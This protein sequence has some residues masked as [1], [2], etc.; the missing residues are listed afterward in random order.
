MQESK[1]QLFQ[2]WI[3]CGGSVVFSLRVKFSLSSKM[4]KQAGSFL[5][6]SFSLKTRL[7]PQSFGVLSCGMRRKTA[8][9]WM[10]LF[11]WVH[12]PANPIPWSL[13]NSQKCKRI[14][15]K[16]SKCKFKF[17]FCAFMDINCCKYLVLRKCVFYVFLW[18]VSVNTIKRSQL[19]TLIATEKCCSNNYLRVIPKTFHIIFY[20][21]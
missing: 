4:V 12:G 14:A 16:V 7:S 9:T 21:I 17:Y 20:I 5:K 19:Q 3:L 8:E 18:W 2:S 1:H 13:S 6:F 11:V 10:C 15:S